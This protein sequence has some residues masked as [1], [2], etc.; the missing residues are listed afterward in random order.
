MQIKLSV[1]TFRDAGLEAKWGRTS[2][3]GPCLYVRNPASHYK[4]QRETW[5]MVTKSM[6]SAMESAG[7]VEGF[8]LQTLIGDVFSV[9][10]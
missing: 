9:R 10:A 5:W 1:K 7:I 4:H 6:H 2:R 3:G 8:T